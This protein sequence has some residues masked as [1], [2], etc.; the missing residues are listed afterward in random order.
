MNVLN[1]DN[2]IFAF[3]LCLTYFNFINDKNN[4]K[5]AFEGEKFI[6]NLLENINVDQ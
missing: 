6:Y 3:Y 2:N 5:C 4:S 1:K